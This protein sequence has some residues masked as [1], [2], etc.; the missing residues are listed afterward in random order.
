MTHLAPAARQALAAG[1][2][3]MLVT[4]V[5]AQGSSPRNTGAAMLVTGKNLVG[6]VGGGRLEYEA[7]ELA[8]ARLAGARVDSLT[9]MALGPALGQCCG[10]KVLLLVEPVTAEAAQRLDA[11][12]GRPEQAVIATRLTDP[13]SRQTLAAADKTPLRPAV[14]EALVTGEPLTAKDDE[15]QRW[16]IEP[17]GDRRPPVLLFGAG[18]VG[19]A[20]ATALAPLPCTVRWI[21]QRTDM[22]P[23]VLPGDT[24]AETPRSPVDLVTEAPANAFYLVMTHTHDMDFQICEAILRRDDFAY[25]GLI[26]S[27]TKRKQFERQAAARGFDPVTLAKLVCPIGITGTTDKQ[28]AVIAALTAAQ[29]LLVFDRWQRPND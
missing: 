19:K 1:E 16:L 22:F 24:V 7:T 3:A 21:D 14:L 5:Q 11:L 15:G 28:P 13:V 25:A 27:A 18:H 10:G 23:P 6:T 4:V 26:G 8:R 12:E 9:E 20:I 2:P 29:L 17:V